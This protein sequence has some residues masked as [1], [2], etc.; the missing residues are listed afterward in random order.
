M[1]NH[2]AC[3]QSQSYI[4]S[5]SVYFWFPF[6]ITLARTP[7]TI[8]NSSGEGGLPCSRVKQESFKFLIIKYDV[9]CRLF[10]DI[11]YQVEEVPL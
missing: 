5:Q 1:D 10:V 9:N 7:N 11:V 6:L 2:V 8:I 3:E 4:F